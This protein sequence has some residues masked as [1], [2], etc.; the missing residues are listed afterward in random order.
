[1]CWRHKLGVILDQ[2]FIPFG[3]VENNTQKQR[4]VMDM[5]MLST[6]YGNRFC[7]APD[8]KKQCLELLCQSILWRHK[9]NLELALTVMNNALTDEK[10]DIT[11]DM[12]RSLIHGLE[13]LYTETKITC[14]DTPDTAHYKGGVRIAAVKLAKTLDKFFCQHSLDLP[15]GLIIWKSVLTNMEEFAEIRII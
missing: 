1:M 15:N 5:L 8:I 2:S 6:H 12:R 3:L 9:E 7:L 13:N 4:E 11:E 14:E 10:E